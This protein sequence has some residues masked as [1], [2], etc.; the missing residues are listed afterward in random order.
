M[1]TTL[2]NYTRRPET[3]TVKRSISGGWR[4]T[5]CIPT[6]T[7]ETELHVDHGHAVDELMGIMRKHGFMGVRI[8]IIGPRSVALADGE[9]IIAE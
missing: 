2:D 9:S 5:L 3:A 1:R 7:Y 6:G 4:G 8:D